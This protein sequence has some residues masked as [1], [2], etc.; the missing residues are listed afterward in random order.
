MLNILLRKKSILLG[1]LGLLVFLALYFQSQNPLWNAHLQV[2]V[3]VWYTRL[4]AFFKHNS[5]GSYKDN[6]LLPAT[7]FYNFLPA[8]FS[9]WSKLNYALYLKAVI[10]LNLLI[11]FI[12][13]LL[14]RRRWQF[15]ILIL[16]FGPISLFRFDTFAAF[17]IILGLIFW[18]KQKLSFSGLALGLATGIKIYPIIFLP[19]LF[20]L[21]R[22]QL[23]KLK[24]FILFYLGAIILPV[25]IFFAFG[26][27]WEQIAETLAFHKNKY[28]SIE[29]VPA[30]LLTATSLLK[31][32]QPPPPL[33]GYGV[34][35]I[36]LNFITSLKLPFFNS[37]WLLPVGLFY[38][39]L[40]FKRSYFKQ[41]NFAIIF[42]LT[43]IFLVF[44]KN[45]N[46]Q[47]IWW[48]LSL[49]PFLEFKKNNKLK[50][51]LMFVLLA[52]IA[53]FDQLVYPLF[54]TQFI[55]NFYQHNQQ[56]AVFYCLLLRNLL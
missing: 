38:L 11:I 41:F 45:L 36:N 1:V 4:T 28:V 21:Y 51:L 56:Y 40:W 35:G 12:S 16:C 50:Y 30:S 2:D 18:Q 24:K 7:L 46:P 49:F 31:F 32:H 42:C 25:L 33:G 47:Y 9:G 43:L 44:S 53:I 5:F 19:Y 13:F 14:S 17:L 55:E 34:W 15:L 52:F 26:G 48:F 3:W 54:Y 10:W 27:R 39:F 22:H 29:S 37:I 20:L 6:E 8:I 23:P